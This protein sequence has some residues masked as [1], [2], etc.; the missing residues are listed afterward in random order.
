MTFSYPPFPSYNGNIAQTILSLVI[1][2]VEIPLIA[3]G[4]VIVDI[5]ESAG[6][7]LGSTFGT[8]LAFPGQIFLQTEASFKPYGIFAPI[9]AIAIWG[10]AIVIFVFLLLKAF[11]IGDDEITESE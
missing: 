8:I 3:I 6:N 10:G 1:W 11:Q 7:S 9:I 4:N 2:V 5:F